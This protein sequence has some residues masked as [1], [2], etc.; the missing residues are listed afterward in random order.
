MIKKNRV[1]EN[2]GRKCAWTKEFFL[3]FLLVTKQSSM[4]NLR[5]NIIRIPFSLVRNPTVSVGHVTVVWMAAVRQLPP[6]RSNCWITWNSAS[7]SGVHAGQGLQSP[8]FSFKQLLSLNESFYTYKNTSFLNVKT[9]QT[10]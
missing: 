3:S 2:L 10:E 4:F 5:L 7:T 6:I 1:E 9:V 8:P